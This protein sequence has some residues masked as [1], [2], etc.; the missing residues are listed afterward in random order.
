MILVSTIFPMLHQKP[1]CR[2]R[3]HPQHGLRPPVVG[4]H[5]ACALNSMFLGY[6]LQDKTTA[7]L[8][9]LRTYEKLK[10]ASANR[11]LMRA[12]FDSSQR[13]TSSGLHSSIVLL[14]NRENMGIIAVGILFLSRVQAEI[15]GNICFRLQATNSDSSLKHTPGSI[16][17]NIRVLP[18]LKLCV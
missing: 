13:Q 18:D 9:N 12:L 2:T 15:C 14:P 5:R 7:K 1:D 11:K 3:T 17:N 6:G 4:A 10:M 8:P 16:R